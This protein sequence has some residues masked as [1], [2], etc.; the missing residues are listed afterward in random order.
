[1]TTT[2]D[3]RRRHATQRSAL[4]A[5]G[6]A[7]GLSISGCTVDTH[8]IATTTTT[9]STPGASIATPGAASTTTAGAER[10]IVLAGR[11]FRARC[12]RRQRTRG[13]RG[14]RLRAVHGRHGTR[15]AE[16]GTAC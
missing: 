1:M 15:P 13:H 12:G 4:A 3:G 2:T 6:L 11:H 9:S 7:L 16:P 10:D 8:P 5:A 14:G